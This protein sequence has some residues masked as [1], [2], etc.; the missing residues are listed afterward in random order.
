MRRRS[1]PVLLA[2]GL[3]L[4]TLLGLGVAATVALGRTTRL[5]LAGTVVRD[6]E[7]I[8]RLA[9]D[10]IHI[11]EPEGYEP[12]FG[13]RG[14]GFALAAYTPGD[15]RGHLMVAR[16]PTWFPMDEDA[17]IRQVR[18]SHT[19]VQQEMQEDRQELEAE[20]ELVLVV[21]EQRAIDL[22]DH[23]VFYS[24]AEG[25]SDEGVAFRSLQVFYPERSGRVVMLFEEP[26]ER[27]DDTRAHALLAS[28]R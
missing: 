13:V 28:I 1:T 6:A 15:K 17:I 12:D 18:N 16:I 11:E 3:L 20:G 26:L 9:A 24:I 4:L 23:S 8:D 19:F 27:W 10:I 2:I 5:G 25:T 21:V 7:I 22:G 14:L